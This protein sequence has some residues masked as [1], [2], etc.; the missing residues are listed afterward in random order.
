MILSNMHENKLIDFFMKLENLP[1]SEIKRIS[2]LYQYK[3]VKK[4]EFFIKVSDIQKSVGFV[5]K[6]LFR[7]YY[8]DLSGNEMT[9]TF[10]IDGGFL[11]SFSSFFNDEKSQINIEALEDSHIFHIKCDILKKMIN[12][13]IYWKNVY[14][15]LLENL[16]FIKE[17]REYDLLL[18][19]STVRY[20]EFL[21]EFPGLVDRVKHYQ[22]ASFLGIKPESLSRIR[23]KLKKI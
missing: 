17:K 10:I 7:H 6:G 20:K 3:F 4:N 16:Y 18:K 9:K 11:I 22:I 1:E 5:I 21:S 19:D 13:N 2:E 23:T 12:E 14:L 8:T 15:R